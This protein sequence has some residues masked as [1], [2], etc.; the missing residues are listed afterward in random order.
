MVSLVL[1]DGKAQI[2]EFSEKVK[3]KEQYIMDQSSVIL[4]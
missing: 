1:F 2:F 3:G 4:K